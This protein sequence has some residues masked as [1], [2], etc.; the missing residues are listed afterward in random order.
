MA[1]SYIVKYRV[2][3]TNRQDTVLLQ[4]GTESEAIKT[5]KSRGSVGK[6]KEI[7]ILSIG[8]K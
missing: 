2:G 1:K 5:L 7:T 3:S 4:N 6:D 8:N